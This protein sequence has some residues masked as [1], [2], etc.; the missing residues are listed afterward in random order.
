MS[1]NALP[2]LQAAAVQAGTAGTSLRA[3]TEVQDMDSEGGEPGGDKEG[4]QDGDVA[5]VGS[6]SK[7]KQSQHGDS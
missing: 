1:D 2:L 3:G 6:E 7:L 4:S 5:E